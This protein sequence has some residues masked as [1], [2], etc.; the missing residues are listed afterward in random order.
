MKNSLKVLCLVVLATFFAGCPKDDAVAIQPPK[1]F[2]EQLPIDAA[3]IDDFLATHF[4]TVD[5][6]YNTTFTLIEPGGTE[7][8]IKDMPNLKSKDVF[9]NDLTYTLY[10]LELNQGDVNGES[11][12]RVDSTFVSYK[13][14][15]LN[16]TVFDIGE[17]PQWFRLD[18]SNLISGWGEIIP[19]FRT[20]TTTEDPDGSGSVIYE[21]FGAGVMFLPSAFAY[22]NSSVG[23]TI[24]AYSPLIFSFKLISQKHRDHDNDRVLSVF[25]YYDT[26]GNVLDTDGDG[27]PN[28]LDI[29]DDG[30]GF[31][32][33]QEIRKPTPILISDGPSLYYPFNAFVVVDNPLTPE[34]E[35]LNSEPKGI[36]SC[37]G[38]FTTPTRIRKHLDPNCN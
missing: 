27:V 25:E 18:D 10:Y 14:M 17:S 4:V 11:P 37:S 1:P 24:P 8:P 20:G 21:N 35:S 2:A 5:A 29:D 33:K 34:D 16:K 26:N 23:T 36:P 28:Y 9:R 6:E 7:T 22:Y 30:D 3:A 19:E 13:G 38:D 32:T 12:I 15:L 31:L